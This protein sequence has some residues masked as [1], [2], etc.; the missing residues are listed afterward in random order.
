MFA[1]VKST[2]F[3][4]S[5]Q[6]ELE[7]SASTPLKALLRD[8]RG[9]VCSELEENAPVMNNKLVWTGLSNLPYGVYTLE[10]MQGKDAVKL[11]MVKRV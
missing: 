5:L 10:L 3:I 1:K 8:D 2:V 11:R 9:F 6:V 4:D 7:D